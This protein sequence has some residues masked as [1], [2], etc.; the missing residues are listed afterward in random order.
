MGNK[1]SSGGNEFAQI[2][3]SLNNIQNLS[4]P[5]LENLNNQIGG[6]IGRG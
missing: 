5:Q 4:L 2:N 3:N 1:N 6:V